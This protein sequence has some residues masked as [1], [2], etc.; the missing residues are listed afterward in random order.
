MTLTTR[1]Q[2]Y[3]LAGAAL[4]LL[5]LA[6]GLAT[7]IGHPVLDPVRLVDTV[8]TGSSILTEPRAIFKQAAVSG[9][10]G[11][12]VFVPVYIDSNGGSLASISATLQYNPTDMS[13][14][15]STGAASICSQYT[16]KEHDEITG[17]FSVSCTAPTRSGGEVV[18]FLTFVVTPRRVGTLPM[19]LLGRSS[20]YA[21]VSV[22]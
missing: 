3:A 11:Q 20:D 18:P 9:S 1:T 6:G 2:T 15:F 22:Q 5:L 17:T 19:Q 12:P 10:V 8:A 14:E 13:V 21:V 4:A 7:W 16:H